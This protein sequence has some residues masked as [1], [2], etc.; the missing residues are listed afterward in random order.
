VTRD[1]IAVEKY[2]RPFAQLSPDAQSA[3]SAQ[4]KKVLKEN[5]YDSAS[6]TLLLTPG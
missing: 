4:V 3:A 2:G 1:T 5:R 6:R